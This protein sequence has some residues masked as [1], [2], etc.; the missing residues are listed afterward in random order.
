MSA[1]DIKS[2]KKLPSMHHLIGDFVFQIVLQQSDS[3]TDRL[4]EDNEILK[5]KVCFLFIN[6]PWHVIS[7]NV[8]F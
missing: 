8:A 7:N 5:S 3:V 2:I 6:E 4:R 1:D